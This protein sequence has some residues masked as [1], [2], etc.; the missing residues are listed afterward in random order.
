MTR[1]DDLASPTIDRTEE[2]EASTHYLTMGG[3][4]KREY[5]A[6]LAMQGLVSNIRSGSPDSM[7]EKPKNVAGWAV[8]FADALI[9]E[10]NKPVSL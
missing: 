9:A 8:A 10:L 6:T 1:P 2:Y 3:L 5:F 7:L 4:T